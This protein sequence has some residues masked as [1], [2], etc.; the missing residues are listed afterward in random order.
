[1]G[2]S[3]NCSSPWPWLENHFLIEVIF[4]PQHQY[5][6]KL[7]DSAQKKILDEKPVF[8]LEILQNTI[9]KVFPYHDDGSVSDLLRSCPRVPVLQIMMIIEAG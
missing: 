6:R 8:Y 9:L 5:V 7:L 1:M 3:L 4:M 2:L